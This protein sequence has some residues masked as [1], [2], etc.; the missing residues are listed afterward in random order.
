[1]ADSTNDDFDWVTA[2]GG[3]TAEQMFVRLL[4]GARKDVDRRNASGFGRDDGWRFEVHADDDRSFEVSR[5]AGSGKASAFVTFERAGARIN[6]SGDGVDVEL[7]AI[8]SINP[9]GHCRYFVGEHEYLGWE[10]RKMAL[11]TLFFERD[12]DE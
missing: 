9:A 10:I 12:E 3:C 1:M 2:Q 7:F 5:V 4:E 8:V 11:D 6:I